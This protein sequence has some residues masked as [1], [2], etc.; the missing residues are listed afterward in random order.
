MTLERADF[1]RLLAERD[2]LRAVIESVRSELLFILSVACIG[3]SDDVSD[4]A[5]R[6]LNLL[7]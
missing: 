6:A 4:A 3:S 5:Q 2:A 1:D 7:P